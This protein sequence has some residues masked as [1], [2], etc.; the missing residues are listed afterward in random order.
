MA[1]DHR[2]DFIRRSLATLAGS[3]AFTALPA[4][5]A[6]A[7]N[8]RPMLRG[9]GIDYRALVCIYLYGGNDCFNMIVPRDA[10]Y[11]AYQATRTN[12]AVAQNALHALSPVQAPIGGGQFGMHPEMRGIADLFNAQRAAIVANVGPLRN[13]SRTATRAWSGRRRAPTPP[14]APAG[15]VASP[16]SSSPATP[17]RRCR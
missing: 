10:G 9:A 4:K 15:A 14:R 12:L 11:A 8:A 16:T 3:A 13:C 6:L 2:R 1:T 17:T 5:L 7:Q